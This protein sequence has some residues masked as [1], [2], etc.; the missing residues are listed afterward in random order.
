MKNKS[1]FTL[2]NICEQ[3]RGFNK[4]VWKPLSLILL[5]VLLIGTAWSAVVAQ[6]Q[7]VERQISLFVFEV[8]ILLYACELLIIEK[9]ERWNLLTLSSLATTGVLAVRGLF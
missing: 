8:I 1:L 5:V 3:M 4:F 2:A 7:Q 6:S 9:R